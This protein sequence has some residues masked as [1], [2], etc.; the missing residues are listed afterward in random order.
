ME[1]TPGPSSIASKESNA[2]RKRRIWQGLGAAIGLVLAGPALAVVLS[3]LA[4]ALLTAGCCALLVVGSP[5]AIPRLIEDEKTR[6][7]EERAAGTAQ[8]RHERL[9]ATATAY[10]LPSG[11][12]VYA[13]FEGLAQWDVSPDGETIALRS[14]TRVGVLNVRTRHMRLAEPPAHGTGNV[15]WLDE[16]QLLVLVHDA[17]GRPPRS[18]AY[19]LL[20]VQ[21]DGLAEL[22]ESVLRTVRAHAVASSSL[23]GKDIYEISDF[24]HGLLAVALEGGEGLAITAYSDDERQAFRTAAAGMRVLY[25]APD[26]DWH[27]PFPQYGGPEPPWRAME[28]YGSPDGNYYAA[29]W[30]D[31][32]RL[33]I[34]RPGGE[35]V[36][37]TSA[38][39]F[40]PPEAEC[41]LIPMGWL[42][43]SQGVLF[44]SRCIDAQCGA[45][46]SWCRHAQR[47]VL[48]LAV[49]E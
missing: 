17:T 27:E 7:V 49:P 18:G 21:G 26:A 33:A 3:L 11:V 41:T 1:G 31:G 24:A 45:W 34:L 25:V 9:M 47:A 39:A 32:A 30:T 38:R 12:E 4:T 8:V 46:L 2:G 40:G 43:D 22:R 48:L 13:P 37:E 36:V 28:R 44:V 29:V 20:Q 23:R 42:P 15:I 14:A 35:V 19:R 10:P 16:R 5:L 6:E